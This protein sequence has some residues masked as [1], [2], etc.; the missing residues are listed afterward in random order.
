MKIAVAGATGLVGTRLCRVLDD[1]GVEVI[2]MSRASG[3]DLFSG[4]RVNEAL[5]GADAVVDCVQSPTFEESQA[6]HFFRRVAV[7]LGRAGHRAG[8]RRHVV[9]S[10]VGCDRFATSDATSDWALAGYYRAKFAHEQ[11]TRQETPGPA[12]LRSTQVFEF[13]GQE[14]ERGRDGDDR[15]HVA[16]LPIQPVDLDETVRALANLATGSDD[17]TEVQ[18]AGPQREHLIDLATAFN[19]HYFDGTTIVPVPSG[20]VMRD[21]ILLPV[22]GVDIA[23]PIFADW[24]RTFPRC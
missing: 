24:L 22:H 8:V 9:L 5:N 2:R 6:T 18:I 14:I 4:L 11:A 10:V 17:R 20:P 23:G 7:I 21:G 16:D 13:V 3:V 1:A 12:V 15:T 19:H